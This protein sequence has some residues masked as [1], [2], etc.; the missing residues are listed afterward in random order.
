MAVK[1]P[2][3]ELK[4]CFGEQTSL[5]KHHIDTLQNDVKKFLKKYPEVEKYRTQYRA[6]ARDVFLD[7]D[8]KLDIPRT[9]AFVEAA[10]SFYLNIKFIFNV[11]VTAKFK[12]LNQNLESAIEKL[13]EN[14]S[15]EDKSE[16]LDKLSDIIERSQK[17]LQLQKEQFDV[18]EKQIANVISNNTIISKT[19]EVQI[20]NTDR[21]STLHQEA[22]TNHENQILNVN[23]VLKRTDEHLNK[24]KSLENELQRDI[25][26]L[27]KTSQQFGSYAD[28]VK[29][30]PDIKQTINQST[31]EV[32]HIQ[33]RKK[34][35]IIF[36]L[37]SNETN[38]S[39]K[40]AIIDILKTININAAVL[41]ISFVGNKDKRPVRVNF[42]N[43]LI[44]QNILNNA[45]LLKVTEFKNVYLTPDRSFEERVKRKE[46]VEEMLKM[47]KAHPTKRWFIKHGKIECEEKF[48]LNK[49][50]PISHRT[51]SNQK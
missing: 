7:S 22:V 12:D 31:K 48:T 34:N 50:E 33:T 2:Y 14:Q 38:N 5:I 10:F 46:L 41:G 17:F 4:S 45:K 36:G 42:A 15:K 40:E 6:T 51:R 35:I 39:I 32:H 8:K 21:L 30:L 27:L 49:N 20:R 23:Q 16:Q 1:S 28:A 37:S 18:H 47:I 9:L 13:S 3:E 43:E 24:S 29:G 19:V 25:T 44:V 26:N 11:G